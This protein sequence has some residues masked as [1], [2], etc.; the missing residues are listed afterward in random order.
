[1]RVRLEDVC[2][3]ESSKLKQSDVIDQNGMYPVYGASGYLGNINTYQQSNYYIAVVKDGAG[4]GR[5]M[6]LPPES[7]IIGTMQYLIPKDNV[8]PEYLYY[9]VKA[10]HLEKYFSGAT[11]P[12]IY[13]KDYKN[14]QF[15]LVSFEEQREI[16]NRLK[17]IEIIIDNLS[18]NLL[19]LDEL[20]K[21]R[22]VEMFGDISIN[23]KNWNN[24]LLGELCKIVRG[25][26]PRPI[27]KFLGGEVPWIKIGDATK[28]DNIY[29]HSTKE[30]IIS[31][32][33]SKSR[34][35]KAGS[36]IF[37]NCGVS[38]GFARIITFDGCI[39]DG[40]LALED[41]DERLDKVFLLQSLNQMTEHFRSIAPAGTQPNLNTAIMKKYRQVIP[42]IELQ[43]E[44]IV[45]CEEIDKSRSRIQKSLEAS[46]E[47]FDS[48]MQEYFG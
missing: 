32:G 10:K 19:L 38:L 6:L 34:L 26:S 9:V 28:G 45:F 5:T 43:R 21:A 23:D 14:E 40:W 27:E 48:L 31:E 16:I 22:F 39:H 44:F 35:V 15:D 20:V 25:G 8:L 4:I 30:H 11:I 2:E 42:P 17:K 41:I 12:H 18:K 46:Q 33:V 1:M 29:L 3:K 13:F 7:S 24:A 47:L 36:L 37:A